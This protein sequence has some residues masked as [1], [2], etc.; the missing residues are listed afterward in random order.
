MLQYPP[1]KMEMYAMITQVGL[2]RRLRFGRLNVGLSQEAVASELGVPR[3]TIS[4][5]ESGKRGVSSLELAKLAELY[6]CPL[7]CFLR[8]GLP[9]SPFGRSSHPTPPARRVPACRSGSGSGVRGQL[10]RLH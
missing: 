9:S 1:S 8:R 4:Q 6:R 2:A 7:T 3:P 5:I 10:P